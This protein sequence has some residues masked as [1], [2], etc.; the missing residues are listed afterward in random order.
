MT[1]SAFHLP[2]LWLSAIC[3]LAAGFGTAYA[4]AQ[5]PFGIQQRWVIGGTGSWDYVKVDSASH[6]LY[7]A[8]QT[9]VEVI[10]LTSGKLIGSI[11]NLKRCHGIAILPDGKTG[12]IT[13]GNANQVVVFDTEKLTTIETIPAGKKPDGI[14]Y[15]ASTNTVWV[16]N[17]NSKSVTV[18]DA[19]SRKPVATIALPGKP[20]FPQTDNE[21]TVFVNIDEPN[22]IVVLDARTKT[23]TATWPL[24]GCKGPSGLAYD[25]D[26][27]RLFSVCDGRKMAVTDARTG[28]PLGL[29]QVGDGPDAAGYDARNDLAFA[30]NEDGTMTVIDAGKPE[31]PAIQTLATM[32]GARTMGVDATTGTIYMVSA[33]L[34]SHI[35]PPTPEVTH[36]RPD[37][38]PGTFTVLVIGR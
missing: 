28:K 33:K 23:L 34:T 30:S 10:D 24:R 15:E 31:F 14:V 9:K 11:G 16:F 6:R 27:K 3:V 20:E 25:Q 35:P 1:K 5:K 26:G 32:K 22:S 18:L 2:G 7:V 29:A 17:G 37:P 36:P 38:V 19:V 8:H 12:F 13:D 21:G 4:Q